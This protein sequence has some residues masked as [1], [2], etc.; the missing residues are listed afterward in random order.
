MA[1]RRFDMSTVKV[2][3]NT[4][5]IVNGRLFYI[6]KKDVNGKT[7]TVFSAYD[8]KTGINVANGFPKEGLIEL[9]D[10]GIDRIEERF[11]EKEPWIKERST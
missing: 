7:H 4:S 3:S 9:L 8:F 11:K 6:V 2:R 1:Y 5:H 10:N